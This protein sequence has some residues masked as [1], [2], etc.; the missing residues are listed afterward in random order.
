MTGLRKDLRAGDEPGTS[1]QRNL[2][3]DTQGVDLD[4]FPEVRESLLE[5]KEKTNQEG[6][7]LDPFTGVRDS[8]ADTK[9]ALE[10]KRGEDEELQITKDAREASEFI[11]DI[12]NWLG[13]VATEGS[14]QQLALSSATLLELSEA[15]WKERL[16]NLTEEKSLTDEQ[17]ASA[18]RLL[19]SLDILS[20]ACSRQDFD[21]I[22]TAAR[23]AN[24]AIQQWAKDVD[25]SDSLSFTR[26]GE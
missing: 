26:P 3:E 11:G 15:E 14:K 2:K 24:E 8:L 12:G 4:P 25:L 13:E 16:K 22:Q 23:N 9:E 5:S 18:K 10:S 19:D 7:D 20:S 21:S 6:I 17:R 1:P